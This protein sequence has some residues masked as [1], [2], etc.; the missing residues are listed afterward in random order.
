MAREAQ[1]IQV[2]PFSSALPCSDQSNSDTKAHRVPV[3]CRHRSRHQVP[4]QEGFLLVHIHACPSA[5]SVERVGLQQGPAEGQLQL[6]A[7]PKK[8]ANKVGPPAAWCVVKP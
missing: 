2:E 5:G 4:L 7:P 8:S 3:A 1:L 6:K